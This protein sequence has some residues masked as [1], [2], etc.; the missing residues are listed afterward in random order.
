MVVEVVSPNMDT[1]DKP[2]SIPHTIEFNKKKKRNKV[3]KLWNKIKAKTLAWII[4]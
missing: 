3:V 1:K 4:K 2:I